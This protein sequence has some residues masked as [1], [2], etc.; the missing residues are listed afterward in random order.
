MKAPKSAPILRCEE[1]FEAIVKRRCAIHLFNAWSHSYNF[2]TK[3]VKEDDKLKKTSNATP[4]P[5]VSCSVYNY[6]E[7]S[8]SSWYVTGFALMCGRS[9]GWT[10]A[11]FDVKNPILCAVGGA[12]YFGRILV[13]PRVPKNP[14]RSGKTCSLLSEGRLHTV[15]ASA[16]HRIHLELVISNYENLQFWCTVAFWIGFVRCSSRRRHYCVHLRRTQWCICAGDDGVCFGDDA[17]SDYGKIEVFKLQQC[18]QM[19]GGQER[20]RNMRSV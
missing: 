8:T 3:Y 1:P 12:F 18:E 17:G 11:P 4:F 16:L 2:E 6:T 7:H 5:H 9:N 19:G 14:C 20:E 13:G 15:D 10:V